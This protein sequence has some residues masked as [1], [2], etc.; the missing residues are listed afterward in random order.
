MGG[1]YHT[2]AAQ[3]LRSDFGPIV[4]QIASHL[5]ENGPSNLAQLQ[6]TALTPNQVRIRVASAGCAPALCPLQ[7]TPRPAE[8]IAR[9]PSQIRSSL[10]VLIQHNIVSIVSAP[11]VGGPSSSRRG[12]PVRPGGRPVYEASIDEV[13]TRRWFTWVVGA[14]RARF[15]DDGALLME[16]VL[17]VGR[18]TIEE[19]SEGAATAH[20]R[21][22]GALA[23]AVMQKRKALAATVT[24]M[25]SARYLEPIDDL[26]QPQQLDAADLFAKPAA[27]PAP[28]TGRGAAVGRGA[29]AGRGTAAARGGRA[30][31]GARGRGAA[32][33]GVAAGA[34]APAGAAAAVAPTAAAAAAAGK[35]KRGAAAPAAPAVPAA[36][37][38]GVAHSVLGAMSTSS[39]VTD[40]A[41]KRLWRANLAEMRQALR[42]EA[43]GK[44][45]GEKFDSTAAMVR[46]GTPCPTPP[47]PI[48]THICI[49]LH[50]YIYV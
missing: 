25:L 23:S 39:S 35:R 24:Q 45:V 11:A 9:V 20:G 33:A 49:Y 46:V 38:A 18:G 47:P 41:R 40:G 13:I 48:Y 22:T 7:P 44:L 29:V 19:L 37:S 15:G 50:K 34:V 16:E 36:G 28:P 10:L 27:K 6:A 8:P 30:G 14:A 1:A 21:A 17:A 12:A 2:A 3:I 31:R 32:P 4:E 26:P 5:L 42:L 43:I